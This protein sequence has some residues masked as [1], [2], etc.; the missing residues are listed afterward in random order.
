MGKKIPTF[1][2]AII[3]F[4]LIAIGAFVY[5]YFTKENIRPKIKNIP[6]LIEKNIKEETAE[7]IIDIKYPQINLP[8][9]E[10]N[11]KIKDLVRAQIDSFKNNGIEPAEEN[12][13]SGLY[14]NYSAPFYNVSLVSIIFDISVYFSGA[15]HPVS[16]ID[17]LNYDL[18]NNSILRLEDIFL[19]DSDYLKIISDYCVRKLTEKLEPDDFTINWIYEGAGPKPENYQ[20]VALSENG[21]IVLFEQYQV[22]SYAQGPQQIEIPYEE[23][24]K[25]LN[26]NFLTFIQK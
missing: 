3:L 7:Y 25:I 4:V 11:Q 16:Y 23:I 17:T 22:V 5:E 14:I 6:Q 12:Y 13:L 2:I 19:P 10:A 1:L 9:A 8:G 15:A 20:N 18:K 21:L 26:P 24:K